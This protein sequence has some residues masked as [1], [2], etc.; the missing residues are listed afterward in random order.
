MTNF[1]QARK[2]KKR[3]D[4]IKDGRRA[5]PTKEAWDHFSPEAQEARAAARWQA[6]GF[7]VISKDEWSYSWPGNFPII[8]LRRALIVTN[9]NIRFGIIAEHEKS[10]TQEFF[11]NNAHPAN[12]KARLD[13]IIYGIMQHDKD[14]F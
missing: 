7:A 5:R 8:N 2:S 14:R 9:S 6:E 13:N 10:D 11:D 4:N 1:K 3:G 12:I